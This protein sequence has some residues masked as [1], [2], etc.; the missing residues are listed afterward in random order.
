MTA[1]SS[2]FKP[3]AMLLAA[4]LAA[5]LVTVLMPPGPAWAQRNGANVITVNT[6]EDEFNRLGHV[7]LLDKDLFTADLRRGARRD[8]KF[9]CAR[10]S[11][12]RSLR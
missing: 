9:L 4:L 10:T 2:S 11:R 7:I 3:A 5:A 1:S 6:D 8:F 12:L